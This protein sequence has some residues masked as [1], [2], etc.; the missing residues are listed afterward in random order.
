MKNETF[1][2]V[3]FKSVEIESVVVSAHPQLGLG[4]AE[5]FQPAQFF[6]LKFRRARNCS[7][8]IRANKSGQKIRLKK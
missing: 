7:L 3:F 8:K 6:G 1:E 2:S 4:R 5:N